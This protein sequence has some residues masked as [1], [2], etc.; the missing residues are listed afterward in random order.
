MKWLRRFIYRYIRYVPVIQR[1]FNWK[2]LIFACEHK[3]KYNHAESA[4]KAAARMNANG[5]HVG[6]VDTYRKKKR[7]GRL[8]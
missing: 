5:F 2:Y 4:I 8:A 3:V 6:R 7:E 1:F